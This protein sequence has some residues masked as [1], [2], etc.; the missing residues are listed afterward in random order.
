[1]FILVIRNLP[2]CNLFDYKKEACKQN[3]QTSFLTKGIYKLSVYG[4]YGDIYIA[5]LG[6]GTARN[7]AGGRGDGGAA[8]CRIFKSHEQADLGEELRN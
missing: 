4:L 6:R 8:G 3:K 2:L 1:M 5:A 7:G